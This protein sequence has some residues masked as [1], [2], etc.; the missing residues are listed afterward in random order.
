MIKN[1]IILSLFALIANLSF[2]QKIYGVLYVRDGKESLDTA[3]M[4]DL[5][6]MVARLN[7]YRQSDADYQ[8][9][10]VSIGTFTL[11]T[12]YNLDREARGCR[13]GRA[14]FC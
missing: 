8:Y 11:A 7:F 12:K 10:V 13:G 1:L 14:V 4:K 6:A 2:A 3:S 5:N 9:K